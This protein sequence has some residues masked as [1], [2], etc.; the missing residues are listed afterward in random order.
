MNL[1]E[2]VRRVQDGETPS[3]IA[4]AEVRSW[5]D[6]LENDANMVV[7]VVDA[8]PPLLRAL[9]TETDPVRLADVGRVIAT[10]VSLID[11]P[12]LAAD[13]NLYCASSLAGLEAWPLALE[14][15]ERAAQASEN[16]ANLVEQNLRARSS[17]GHC[18]LEIGRFEDAAA[19]LQA[20]LAE[21][22]L[23]IR[24]PELEVADWT[25]LGRALMQLYRYDE[26]IAAMQTAID[27]EPGSEVALFNLGELGLAARAAAQL[28]RAIVAFSDARELALHLGDAERAAHFLSE[29]ALTWSFAG[30][31][32]RAETVL[33]QAAHEAEMIG[34]AGDAARWRAHF[35]AE[36]T[37]LSL[38]SLSASELIARAASALRHGG[39]S[40]Q[41]G[42]EL[43]LAAVR[44][45]AGEKNERGEAEARNVLGLLYANGGEAMRG[46]ASLQV[47]IAISERLHDE[48]MSSRMLTNAALVTFNAG[49][50]D[51]AETLLH[52]AVAASRKVLD[53]DSST[54]VRQ[55]VRGGLESAHRL[56]A[57]LYGARKHPRSDKLIDIGQRSRAMNLINWLAVGDAIAAAVPELE[58]PFL[59]WRASE[60][61]VE[62]AAISNSPRLRT[63]LYKRGETHLAF[64]EAARH[65]G[66]DPA[67]RAPVLSMEQIGS[68]LRPGECVVDV[69]SAMNGIVLTA[70]SHTGTP[71]TSF[72]E[73]ESNERK[74]FL[75]RWGRSVSRREAA[76]RSR[77]L[78]PD[79]V[80]DSESIETLAAE[81]HARVLSEVTRLIRQISAGAEH[82]FV[83]PD[84]QVAHFPLWSLTNE[85]PGASVSVVPGVNALGIL[86][87]RE[88]TED[89]V[90]VA[91]SDVTETLRYAP[92]EIEMLK[93]FT[94]MP[95]NKAGVIDAIRTASVAHFAGHATFN[96]RNP[97]LSGVV[98]ERRHGRRYELLTVFELLAR[99]RTPAA[100]LVVLSACET[101]VPRLHPANEFVGMPSA[102][103][104]AGA[105]NVIASLWRVD[106]GAT[107]L[108]MRE[109]YDAMAEGLTPSASLA[110]A[111]RRI[112]A[113]TREEVVSR[114]GSE[115]SVPAAA[116]PYAS[117][118]FIDAFHHYGAD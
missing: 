114:L 100:H 65:C 75:S 95:A 77:Y 108:L 41:K 99:A 45:A 85:L 31:F 58:S 30:E 80:P 79:V 62:S 13:A 15:A 43:A 44:K 29:L 71:A 91:L 22:Q 81:L 4:V 36:D 10:A 94:R 14:F 84:A 88:R 42:I 17:A 78:P 97:Y 82:I 98:V 96:P 16:A 103:L 12:F 46:L 90:R 112:A 2:I 25:V 52:R 6:A 35:R 1:E 33:A 24:L 106:D 109:L 118:K 89:G 57:Q 26:A 102:F 47:A 86:R 69:L 50:A 32:A 107:Y 49:D 83:V 18:Q 56:L 55:A 72:V 116:R 64:T 21:P 63:L 27:R 76:R 68:V 87:A 40:R 3:R 48:Q 8:V 111:R 117:S 38:D 59:A 7:R 92:L 19:T 28:D 11:L 101:G 53:S 5:A 113:M 66:F 105:R 39:V 73:W 115:V 37:P 110:A 54:E 60:A 104:I 23:A 61:A 70:F 67:A 74:A 34:R 20:V 51:H 9:R 93:G